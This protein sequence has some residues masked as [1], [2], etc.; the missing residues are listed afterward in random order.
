MSLTSSYLKESNINGLLKQL[1]LLKNKCNKESNTF[2]QD[3]FSDYFEKKPR[4]FYR[5]LIF[6]YV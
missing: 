1:I 3:K 5:N 4:K 6:F 2:K